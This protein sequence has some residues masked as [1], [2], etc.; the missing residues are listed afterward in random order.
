MLSSITEP[1]YLG[2]MCTMN[3]ILLH[4]IL[5]I[6]FSFVNFSMVGAQ[7]K[8]KARD[9]SLFS[10]NSDRIVHN[11]NYYFYLFYCELSLDKLNNFN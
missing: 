10:L 1:K 9:F 6:L 7:R 8:I 5:F 2:S 4:L 3:S 11:N